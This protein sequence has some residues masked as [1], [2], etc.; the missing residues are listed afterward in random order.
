[1]SLKEIRVGRLQTPEYYVS[2]DIDWPE[3]VHSSAYFKQRVD[4]VEVTIEHGLAGNEIGAP[5]HLQYQRFRTAL[6]FNSQL[7]A[8]LAEDFPGCS[9]LQMAALEK[10]SW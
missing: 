1:M 4:S 10:T 9:K 7:Y 6:V 3:K 2:H 5:T 8:K